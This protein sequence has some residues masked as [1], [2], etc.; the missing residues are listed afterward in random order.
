[1]QDAHVQLNLGLP[2]QKQHSLRRRPFLTS[3][4][5]RGMRDSDANMRTKTEAATG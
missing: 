3:K 4:L 5:D 2:R 1:M